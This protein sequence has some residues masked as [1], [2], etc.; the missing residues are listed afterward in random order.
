MLVI[1]SFPERTSRPASCLIAPNA[2]NEGGLIA[3]IVYGAHPPRY[4]YHLTPEVVL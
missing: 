1:F 3:A 2:W 4:E